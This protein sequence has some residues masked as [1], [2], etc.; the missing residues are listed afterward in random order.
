M[1]VVGPRLG[2]RRGRKG[3]GALLRERD[4]KRRKDSG[5]EVLLGGELGSAGERR[6][7]RQDPVRF[8]RWSQHRI[9][10][11]RPILPRAQRS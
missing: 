2:D 6:E 3:K 1:Q 5:R 10:E 9:V 8:K 7:R 11:R 4:Q